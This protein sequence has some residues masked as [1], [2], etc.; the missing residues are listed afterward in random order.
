M[1]IR[2]C[3][4]CGNTGKLKLISKMETENSLVQTYFCTN[5]GYTETVIWEKKEVFGWAKD[6]TKIYNKKS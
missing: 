6:G 1:I 2:E 3:K 5:C 4:S